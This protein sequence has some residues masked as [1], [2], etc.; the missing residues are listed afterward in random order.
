MQSQVKYQGEIFKLNKLI[1]KFMWNKKNARI[2][3]RTME[4]KKYEKELGLPNIRT[5]Y[6]GSVVIETA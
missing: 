4:K 1:L 5:Y 2:V 6:K 3:R